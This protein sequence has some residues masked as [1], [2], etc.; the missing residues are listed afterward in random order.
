MTQ[1]QETL[2]VLIRRKKS[3]I[4]FL[5]RFTGIYTLTFSSPVSS[6]DNKD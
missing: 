4:L 1:K 3:L 2:S 6:T 5:L